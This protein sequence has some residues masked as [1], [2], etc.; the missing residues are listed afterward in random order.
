M[1]LFISSLIQ[2]MRKTHNNT[3]IDKEEVAKF[4]ALA[5]EWWDESGKFKPLHDINPVR[6]GY[7]KEK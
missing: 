1:I 5:K 3:T 4:S 6:I 2:D 7:I